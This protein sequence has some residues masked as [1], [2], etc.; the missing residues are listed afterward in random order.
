MQHEAVVV[1]DEEQVASAA[2]MQHLTVDET[3]VARDLQQL[4]LR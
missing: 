4:L 1:A 2:D 3:F